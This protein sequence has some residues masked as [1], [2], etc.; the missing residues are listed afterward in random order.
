MRLIGR[1][2]V[3]EKRVIVVEA[4]PRLVV[5]GAAER[6]MNTKLWAIDY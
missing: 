5:R 3:R 2:E 6:E 1:G 4:I